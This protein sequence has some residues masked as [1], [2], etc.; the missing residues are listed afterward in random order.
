VRGEHSVGFRI[1]CIHVTVGTLQ[2]APEGYVPRDDTRGT[3]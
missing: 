3:C 1:A 2:G